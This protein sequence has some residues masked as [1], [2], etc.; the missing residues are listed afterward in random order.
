MGEFPS[1]D[2]KRGKGEGTGRPDDEAFRVSLRYPPGI[3]SHFECQGSVQQSQRK[4]KLHQMKILHNTP[5]AAQFY[6]WAAGGTVQQS[7]K[8]L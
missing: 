8:G 3:E 5:I 1:Q 7:L 4:Q 2:Q 6:F